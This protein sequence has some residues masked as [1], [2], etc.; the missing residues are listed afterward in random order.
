MLL[1]NSDPNPI[2]NLELTL[3]LP[4]TFDLDAA[5]DFLSLLLVP[6]LLLRWLR[7]GLGLWLWLG[8]GLG[9]WLGL[10]LGLGLGYS[11]I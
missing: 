4:L 3:S 11:Q 2:S 7:L 6:F 1:L 8:L 10:G 5:V 9:L